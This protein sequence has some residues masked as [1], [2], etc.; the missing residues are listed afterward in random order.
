MKNIK[1]IYNEKESNIIYDEYYFN[2]ISMPIL[3]DITFNDIKINS[4][5]I[6]WKIDDIKII[7]IDNKEIKYKVEIRKENEQFKSIY[8]GNDTNCY[9]NKLSSNTYYEI[10]ILSIYDN[11]NSIWSEIKKVKTQLFDSIILNQMK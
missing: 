4:F 1:I 10:R 2:G 8:E 5:N 3:K 11:I 7:N 9:I 6:S